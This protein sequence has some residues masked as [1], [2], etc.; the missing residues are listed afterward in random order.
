MPSRQLRG[1]LRA[2]GGV[3]ANV[4]KADL[5]DQYH[6]LIPAG[7]WEG[8]LAERYDDRQLQVGAGG[9]GGSGT[10]AEIA[11]DIDNPLT[12]GALDRLPGRSAIDLARAIGGTAEPIEVQRRNTGA[13]I[14]L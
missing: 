1:T 6:D 3:E 5:V 12:I 14:H 7:R 13:T 10:S 8:H 9:S 11:I 2:R 4:R